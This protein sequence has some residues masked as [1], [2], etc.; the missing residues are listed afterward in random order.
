MV[1]GILPIHNKDSVYPLKCNGIRTKLGVEFGE[2]LAF[3]VSLVNQKNGKYKHL[4]SGKKIGFAIINSCN[5][6]LVVQSKLMRFKLGQR[7]PS[8]FS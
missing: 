5:Q 1:C 4:F 3:A 8:G 6:P 7:L 2:A